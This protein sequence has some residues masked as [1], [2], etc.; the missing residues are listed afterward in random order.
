VRACGGVPDLSPPFEMALGVRNSTSDLQSAVGEVGRHPGPRKIRA[1]AA[2]TIIYCGWE[3]L[4]NGPISLTVIDNWAAKPLATFPTCHPELRSGG[5]P[6]RPQRSRPGAVNFGL[7][8]AAPCTQP[9]PANL[10]STSK[11]A[12]QTRAPSRIPPRLPLAER[13]RDDATC[14]SGNQRAPPIGRPRI[15]SESAQMTSQDHPVRS[16]SIKL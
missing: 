12:D 11:G 4:F 5:S 3:F 2:G 8:S 6:W 15:R 10:S 14:T 16:Q 1:A 9:G 7:T 13:I